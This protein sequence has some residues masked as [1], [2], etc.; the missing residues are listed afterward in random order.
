MQS[1]DGVHQVQRELVPVGQD[2]VSPIWLT[3]L[4]VE[5]ETRDVK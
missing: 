4:L 3:K 1:I 2:G 5:E